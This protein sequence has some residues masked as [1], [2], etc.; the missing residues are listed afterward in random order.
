MLRKSKPSPIRSALRA[1]W[2]LN[3]QTMPTAL[4]WAV[5]FWF[6][7]EA[8]SLWTRLIA[9]CLANLATLVSAV[10]IVRDSPAT[11]KPE[12]ND[13]I[14]DRFSWAILMGTGLPFCLALENVSRLH[15][16]NYLSKV[17]FLSISLS[18]LILWLL[19]VSVLVPL[20]VRMDRSEDAIAVFAEGLG[21]L[22][23]KKR[24]VFTS[25]SVL[26][27]AWPIF[28]VYAFLA[29]TFAQC[30]TLSFFDDTVDAATSSPNK[31]VHI[32]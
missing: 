4:V 16:T 11:K 10:L 21:F 19:A 2:D 13:S 27:F 24:R 17:V 1:L 20:R 26:T 15:N 12:W 8:N 29:L 23:N 28:F 14:L 5:S 7:L 31:R 25:L 30:M 3:V 22:Q 9:V 32:A 6:I 18:C